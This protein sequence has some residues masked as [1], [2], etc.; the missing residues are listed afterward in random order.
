M[1]EEMPIR[2]YSG[3]P[4]SEI[5]SENWLGKLWDFVKANKLAGDCKTTKVSRSASGTTISSMVR[6]GGG[7]GGVGG[8]SGVN[9]LYKITDTSQTV[10]ETTI[11][12]IGFEGGEVTIQSN[13][14]LLSVY[15]NDAETGKTP[16]EKSSIVI[17]AEGVY[18]AYLEY[19]YDFNAAEAYCDLKI[20]DVNKSIA[21]HR[22]HHISTI[23]AENDD[24][25]ILKIKEISN[26]YLES[27]GLFSH[28]FN[29]KLIDISNLNGSDCKVKRVIE[30]IRIGGITKNTEDTDL[31]IDEDLMQVYASLTLSTGGFII[32]SVNIA[33]SIPQMSGDVTNG[34]LGGVAS[35]EVDGVRRITS[36]YSND[37]DWHSS[38][39]S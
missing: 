16:E 12:S 23:I 20:S 7:G 31:T 14:I 36:L 2:P 21:S 34:S 15:K 29:T 11:C 37:I 5:L 3:M 1:S 27:S 19:N 4:K 9:Y 38:L 30:S 26:H 13:G 18:R 22:H 25:G 35:S 32:S 24:E 8:E 28:F 33:E 6:G 39:W 10:G 17:T